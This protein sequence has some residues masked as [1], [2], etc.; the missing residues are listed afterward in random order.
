MRRS[1][2]TN[3][4]LMLLFLCFGAKAQAERP[5]VPVGITITCSCD[6]ATGKAY[7][8]AIRDLLSKDSHYREMGLE[9]GARNHAIRVNIISM[10]LEAVDGRPRVALSI[11]CLHDGS[12]L[13]QFVETCTRIPIAECAESMVKGL[14]DLVAD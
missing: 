4:L 1:S 9:E 5:H 3:L 7:V 10:P 6:D 2:F 14:S 11:V 13:H 12:M 8:S